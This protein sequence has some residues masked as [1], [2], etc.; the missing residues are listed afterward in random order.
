MSQ[1]YSTRFYL[2]EENVWNIPKKVFRKYYNVLLLLL[3]M[4]HEADDLIFPLML[5]C[6]YCNEGFL[7]PS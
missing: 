5:C 2:N 6:L 7:Y 1:E 3:S 4:F